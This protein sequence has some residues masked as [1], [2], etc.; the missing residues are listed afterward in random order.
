MLD[1]RVVNSLYRK[2]VKDVSF[3][4]WMKKKTCWVMS[5]ANSL[6]SR[7]YNPESTAMSW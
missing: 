5:V 3:Y 6:P 7:S 2:I 1:M 4:L